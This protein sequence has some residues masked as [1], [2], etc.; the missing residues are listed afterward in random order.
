M[1]LLTDNYLTRGFWGDEAWTSLISQLPYLQMLKTT[2]ADFHP[3]AYYTIVELVYKFL[4][5]TEI[6]TRSISIF[7]YL[8]T[9]VL[10]W[11]LATEV[12]GKLFGIL[13]AVAVALNP[14]FFTYAF[15][16]RNYTMFAFTATGS[17]YFLLKF[18]T[19]SNNKQS[20]RSTSI[21]TAGLKWL[22]PFVFF[23]TLGIYTHY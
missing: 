18:S 20:L 7:F 9:L 19:S 1:S 14:I 23:S 2:A 15:E 6:V 22:I 12:K 21:K 10:V 16:A 11:R 8:L 5:P 4:P 13:S 17:I 3:P